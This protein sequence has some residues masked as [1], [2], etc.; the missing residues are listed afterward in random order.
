LYPLLDY[1]DLEI[2]FLMSLIS[3][4][5]RF[6][7]R[8]RRSS[9]FSHLIRVSLLIFTGWLLMGGLEPA[10]SAAPAPTRFA[11]A[12]ST[13]ATGLPSS[14]VVATDGRGNAYVVSSSDSK[15]LSKVPS[16]CVST[17]CQIPVPIDVSINDIA[18]VTAD[19][20]G[21]VFLIV[22]YT[23][24]SSQPAKKIIEIPWTSAGYAASILMRDALPF[25]GL[26]VDASGTNLYF[27]ITN[28]PTFASVYKLPVANPGGSLPAFA[29]FGF[30]AVALSVDL[31]NNVYLAGQTQVIKFPWDSTISAYDASTPVADGGSNMP[32]LV[33]AAGGMAVSGNGDVYISDAGNAVM[34]HL[35]FFPD[36][37]TGGSY[38]GPM[39]MVDVSS[40]GSVSFS[41]GSIAADSVGNVYLLNAA[42][43]SLLHLQTL[44]TD[45]G[46]GDIGSSGSPITLRF[47]FGGNNS[48]TLGATKVLTQGA[49]NMDFVDT[50]A[51]T[52]TTQTVPH[53]YNPTDSCTV[54]VSFSPK[55]PGLRSGAVVLSDLNGN[56]LATAT[57]HGKGHGPQIAFLS[58]AAKLNFGTRG[59]PTQGLA[60]DGQGNVYATDHF[61]SKLW[62]L[63]WTGTGYGTVTEIPSQ[64]TLNNPAG[65]AMD[66]AGN[67]F[68][69]ASGNSP[70][71]SL[72]EVP[73]TANGFGTPVAIDFGSTWGFAENVAVDGAG[74]LF[75]VTNGNLVEVPR[76]GAGF[77]T[78]VALNVGTP[79]G[80]SISTE[81]ALA[82]DGDENI[83]I[84]DS[85]NNRL[86]ELPWTG[87]G[88]GAAVVLDSDLNDPEGIAVDFMGNVYI[89]DYGNSRVMEMPRA[90]SGFGTPALLPGF[91]ASAYET[92]AADAK[93]NLYIDDWGN[94]QVLKLDRSDAPQV[95]FATA[96]A[97]GIADATDGTQTVGIS[98]SG[99]GILT[100]TTL[101]SFPA[102]F[103]DAGDSNPCASNMVIGGGAS[104]NVSINF[105]PA[106]G[107]VITDSITLTDNTLNNVGSTQ[108]ISLSGIGTSTSVTPTLVFQS[109]PDHVVGDAP[110]TVSATS[111]SPGAITYTVS[112]G[113]ATISGSTLTVTGV[114]LVVLHANQVATEGFTA[115]TVMT[116]F[117]VNA[118]GSGPMDPNLHFV[119]IPTHTVGDA[120]FTVSATSDSPGAITYK[121]VSGPATISGS[122]LT[123][124][125]AGLVILSANQPSSGD[126]IQGTAE[127]SFT[128]NA[129]GTQPVTPTLS[130]A[131]IPA[132][133]V[134]DAPFT[135][136]ATSESNGAVTYAVT[137]GP[138]TISGA[139]VTVTG[140]GT[141]VLNASQTASG[142]YTAATATASFTV[143]EGFTLSTNSGSGSSGTATVAQ[144]A[145]ATFTLMLT[146]GGGTT[147]PNA[148]SLSATGLPPGATATFSPAII[149]AGSKATP[150][151]L[152]IQTSNQTTRSENPS[153]NRSPSPIFWG[154][155]LLPLAGVKPIRRRLQR[156]PRLLIAL[157]ALG[158]VAGLIGCGGHDTPTLPTV[159]S[160]T[161]AVTATDQVTG[162]K[163]S[164][165]VTLNV[166]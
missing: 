72:M 78:A 26:A 150:V 141:V 123:V 158:A 89:M 4:S 111:N 75:L 29:S 154:L 164:V 17:D 90:V 55:Y 61:N 104:C 83:F 14:A 60:V 126:F 50:G 108:T 38:G 134:G 42:N 58:S 27:S 115:R 79:G 86:I 85:S 77:G 114:G 93:G 46:D 118:A 80:Q 112:S 127:I 6:S 157:V 11:S 28:S 99:D 35:P 156:M 59:M 121:V 109:V 122:T 149:A 52:C 120:P 51:G 96:T 39:D 82:I 84:A 23:D 162:A 101:S 49:P 68:I 137:S 16:G 161:V 15:S 20:N 103:P 97:V 31:N 40:M 63:P 21:D 132:H 30:A 98:N 136:S 148:L 144:G 54:V 117:T 71:P 140:A 106:T 36:P 91:D 65:L 105:N 34:W 69:A 107:G 48:V 41:P 133:M 110:F 56:T 73:W 62:E 92:L 131:A 22:D 102:S 166:Q 95:S 76:T 44:S 25:A 53:N 12:Q 13:I 138:A 125:G 87:S 10:C 152:T 147:Y 145:P 1:F 142:N 81:L 18:A 88:F 37:T 70:N 43:G 3:M 130:F 135:V 151:T 33:V 116:T 47:I 32:G 57:L 119:A 155:L 146:P 9:S 74:N 159:K 113:P 67:L 128:V 2:F 5:E 100:L 45:F 66:G 19:A 163:S 8:P 153:S 7:R 160:Y 64:G 139:T 94:G 129:A 124:T 24:G 165:N 143:T